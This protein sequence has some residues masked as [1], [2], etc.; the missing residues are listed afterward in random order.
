MADQIG[1]GDLFL[2]DGHKSWPV[3]YRIQPREGI[4]GRTNVTGTIELLPPS[5][6]GRTGPSIQEVSNHASDPN[7]VLL[8]DLKKGGQ[9]VFVR[10]TGST[11]G[12]Y[13]IGADSH[14]AAAPAWTPKKGGA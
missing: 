2:G 9:W 5:P 12:I 8:L 13:D 7:E 14:M 11:D 3:K 4:R 6:E 1:R 10:L